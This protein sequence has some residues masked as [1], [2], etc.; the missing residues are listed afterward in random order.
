MNGDIQANRELLTELQEPELATASMKQL[1]RSGAHTKAV[2]PRRF[3]I[4]CNH[5]DKAYAFVEQRL[6][7][8]HLKCAACAKPFPVESSDRSEVR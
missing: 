7:S 1:G 2:Q 5:T 6:D 4:E 8:D 3:D